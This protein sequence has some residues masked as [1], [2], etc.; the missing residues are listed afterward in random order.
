MS[1]TI[2][3]LSFVLELPFDVRL[4]NE[5]T[6]TIGL[7]GEKHPE[8]EG[9]KVQ[10]LPH[11]DPV[12]WDGS[13]SV[14]LRFWRVPS[15]S[16]LDLRHAGKVIERI[17]AGKANSDRPRSPQPKGPERYVTVVEMVTPVPCAK[18]PMDEHLTPAFDQCLE[19]LGTFLVTYTAVTSDFNVW[20]VAREAL[21][22]FAFCSAR[23]ADDVGE[24]RRGLFLLHSN[25]PAAEDPITEE[26]ADRIATLLSVRHGGGHPFLLFAEWYAQAWRELRRGRYHLSVVTMETALEVFCD[27]VLRLILET[28]GSPQCEWLP[29]FAP[30]RSFR[31]RLRS[32]FHPRLGGKFDL[33]DAR[34]PPGLWYRDLYEQRNRIVH[35]GSRVHRREAERALTAG[36]A[37]L[38]YVI[39]RLRT[40]A[41]RYD[42]ILRYIT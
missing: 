30:T 9:I 5:S 24:A 39:S 10:A 22:P 29:L 36:E 38:E 12:E 37:L 3:L 31:G 13:P 27:T 41:P 21:H 17:W 11:T 40:K 33:T 4:P 23:R 42:H 8:L 2:Y 19:V 35:A 20:P 6:F 28:E 14:S 18:D 25:V 32:E 7:Q 16:A 1:R 26:Q 15:Q 34:H